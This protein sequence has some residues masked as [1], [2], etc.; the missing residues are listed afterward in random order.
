VLRLRLTLVLHVG[1]LWVRRDAFGASFEMRVGE[2][3]VVL[4]F[5]RTE[6][7][8]LTWVPP[9][10][11]WYRALSSP[12][13][14]AQTDEEGHLMGPASAAIATVR[15]VKI[16]VE[17]DFNGDPATTPTGGEE[18]LDS[19]GGRLQL[20]AYAGHD[21]TVR[22]VA[23]AHAEGPQPWLGLSG[24]PISQVG[25]SQLENLH[26]GA[27]LH[28]GITLHS[29]ARMRRPAG[30]LGV[31]D[32]TR[33]AEHV[34][35]AQA[36]PVWDTLLSDAE[37]LVTQ[38]FGDMIYTHVGKAIPH[39][40]GADPSRAILMAAIACEAKARHRVRELASS[41]Q[42]PLVEFII[43][44]SREVEVT[45]ANGLFNELMGLVGGRRL[46][47]GEPELWTRIDRLFRVRN[48]IAH[49]G[50]IAA[51]EDAA[52]LV[53]AAR[54]AFTWLDA[55]PSSLDVG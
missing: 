31:G 24:A 9:S 35:D 40:R 3:D 50:E 14:G 4:T 7:D 8:F 51:P 26:T 20:A 29:G 49:G 34:R 45:A 39:R 12:V 52:E 22:F 6:N 15:H 41:V 25:P 37:H 55:D 19:L 13:V 33:F 46:K 17:F 5:P 2:Y 53:E 28:H 43:T 54:Q 47:D 32:F 23:W 1:D 18:F 42:A 30:A 48:K 21:A 38:S 11:F 44:R 27:P 10:G 16:A 36:P